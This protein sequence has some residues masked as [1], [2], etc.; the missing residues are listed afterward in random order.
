MPEPTLHSAVAR[1]LHTDELEL[2]APMGIVHLEAIVDEE[3]WVAALP[4]RPQLG[5]QTHLVLP[6]ES[7][8]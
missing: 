3:V 1:Y 6:L 4:L 7:K 2:A 5:G 8:V